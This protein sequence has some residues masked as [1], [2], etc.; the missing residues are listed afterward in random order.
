MKKQQYRAII[1]FI[2]VVVAITLA[3]QVYWNYKNYQEGKAQLVRDVQTVLD[4]SLDDYYKEKA[5]QNT[6]G[7]F[8]NSNNSRDFL[9][10]DD[11]FS[12]NQSLDSSKFQLQSIFIEDNPDNNQIITISGTDAEVDSIMGTININEAANYSKII[13]K[14]GEGSKRTSFKVTGENPRFVDSVADRIKNNIRFPKSKK[15]GRS[16]LIKDDS[17]RFKA[18]QN[19]TTSIV[20]SFNDDRLDMVILDSLVSKELLRKNIKELDHSLAYNHRNK[21]SLR[22][23]QYEIVVQ[24]KSPLLPQESSIGI[25]FNNLPSLVFKRNLLGILLSIILVGA[26]ISTLLYLLKIIQEQKQLAEI[27]NDF[28]SNITHEFKTPIATIGVAMESIQHFNNNDDS[29]KTKKYVDMSSQ[30]VSKL[31]IMVEKL[32]ETAT[33][34][35]Q[36]LELK[37]QEVN[38]SEL[39]EAI[40][41]KY[42]NT[43]K[44]EINFSSDS[45]Q[46][47]LPLDVFH[48][49][50]AIDNIVDNAIKYGGEKVVIACAKTK[51]GIQI[52][53][54]DNGNNLLKSQTIQIF[55]KFYR[56]PKGNTHNVKGFGIG[57]YYTKT[58]IEKHNGSITVTTNPTTFKIVL[59]YV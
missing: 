2:G 17:L 25:G 56:V 23:E 45:D 50:N 24:S 42:N 38:I 49:E 41:Q 43:Q 39:L 6:R 20:L 31:N 14:K 57:L 9:G 48:M 5:T 11:F 22:L 28:I 32:L 33:L 8:R 40:T 54:A 15:N 26:I 52:T 4:K 35:S 18:L 59:P 37:M 30:Q 3:T 19:L 34:D 46:M 16:I 55:E 53:I 27:K 13:E 21:D 10:S 7:F 1:Y 29:E 12:F 51:N 58:I 44:K 36:A 47:W